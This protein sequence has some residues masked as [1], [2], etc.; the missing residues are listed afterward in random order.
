MQ[1]AERAVY[2]GWGIRP[3]QRDRR[4]RHQRTDD[5]RFR[6]GKSENDAAKR[7]S[8]KPWNWY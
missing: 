4:T 3:R 1:H 5:W 8:R 6:V 2:L 7:L